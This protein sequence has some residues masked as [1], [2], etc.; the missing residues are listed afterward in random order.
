MKPIL[1][2][3]DAT[4]FVTNGF[5]RMSDAISCKVT[6]ERNGEYQLEMEYPI[7]GRHYTDMKERMLLYSIHD[8]SK[9]RQPFRIYEITKPINGKVTVRA[10]HISYDLNKIVVSP[11]T[12][13]SCHQ[14]ISK[15]Q[16]YSSTTNPFTFTT[17]KQVNAPFEVKVPTICRS[18]LGGTEGSIL[19]VFGTGEYQWGTQENPWL[20]SLHLHRGS[21][22]NVVISYGKNLTD[23]QDV[24][25]ISG[26]YN[27][28]YPYWKTT[29]TTESGTQ[30][31]EYV[32]LS[33]DNALSGRVIVA[34]VKD[35]NN[36]IVPLPL[37]VIPLD[38][39]GKIT[40][41][42]DVDLTTDLSDEVIST[43]RTEL[44]NKATEYLTNNK[45]WIGKHTISVSFVALWQTEEYK[46]FAPLDRLRLCDT[47]KVVH[48]NLGVSVRMK[49]VKVVYDVLMERYISMDLGDTSTSFTNS[50]KTDVSRV[51]DDVK[52]S[53]TPWS[54]YKQA[55]DRATKLISGGLGGYVYLKP[56]AN[57]EPEEI[58]IMDHPNI[59]DAVNIIRM[60]KNGIGYSNNGYDP[61]AFVSAWTIDGSFTTQF[62]NTWE[63]NANI[64][65]T[66]ILTAYNGNASFNLDTGVIESIG[67]RTTMNLDS[68][69]LS[70]YKDSTLVGTIIGDQW[71]YQYEGEN[72]KPVLDFKVGPN[73]K[74]FVFSDSNT[75]I[76]GI[77]AYLFAF[78]CGLDPNGYTERFW[79]G[80]TVAFQDDATF[81]NRATVMSY[82]TY[83]RSDSNNKVDTYCGKWSDSSRVYL[84]IDGDVWIT[85]NLYGNSVKD[86]AVETKHYG[87]VGLNAMESTTAVFSDLGSGTVDSSGIT[88]CYFAPDFEETI[89]LSHEYQVFLTKTSKGE[90]DRAEKFDDYF[91]VY[92]SPG[93]TFDWMVYA[94]QIDYSNHRLERLSFEKQDPNEKA[95]VYFDSEIES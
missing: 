35:E 22:T 75:T 65:K 54:V 89:D 80:D 4:T 12:A 32:Y 15:L 90:L 68:G 69:A 49:I 8:D 39:S 50:L 9:D 25:D 61:T 30:I 77:D 95:G 85:G 21:D 60:N 91:V 73:S 86:R 62:I 24:N 18:I 56:N 23:L 67:D 81:Y 51:I 1:F 28:V 52:Q 3:A 10:R 41:P 40:L 64:I 82:L 36:Q 26:T 20:V 43:I 11:F 76:G 87:T 17:D 37:E 16:G 38:L 71:A 5:G 33:Q 79:F 53:I 58:L 47:V 27:A 66:G 70:F 93:T 34:E 63:L 29:R 57:G 78:N 19:D 94:K 2:S 88:Y 31:E 84:Y 59:A 45:P 92:G 72:P 83:C 13:D 6:E 48:K 42:D 46:N 55:I 74:G 7:S 14:A 44:R